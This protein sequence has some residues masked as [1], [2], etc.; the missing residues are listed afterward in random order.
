TREM[1]GSAIIE[2]FHP[3]MLYMKDQNAT[4]SCGW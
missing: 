1:D 2:Y 4:E 3:L